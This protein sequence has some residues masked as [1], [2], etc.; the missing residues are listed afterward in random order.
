MN[1]LMDA[2]TKEK[3]DILEKAMCKAMTLALHEM[4][5]NAR[6]L[7]FFSTPQ[8]LICDRKSA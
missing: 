6:N 8:V 4:G 5:D 2:D 3:L 1:L 7:S